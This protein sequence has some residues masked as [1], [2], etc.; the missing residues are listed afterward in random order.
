[1]FS[2]S[3]INQIEQTWNRRSKPPLNRH[4][5]AEIMRIVFFA[6]IRREEG[7]DVAI[8]ASVIPREALGQSQTFA[9]CVRFLPIQ[10]EPIFSVDLAAKLSG[11][12]DT[13]SSSFIIVPDGQQFKVAGIAYFGRHASALDPDP[14]SC[15]APQTLTI[16]ARQPGHLLIAYGNGLI[17]RVTDGEF[18]PGEPTPLV[19]SKLG[20][21]I[22]NRITQHQGF[23][24]HE[25]SYW[26]LYSRCLTRLLTF[27][28]ARGHGGSILWV[29]TSGVENLASCVDIR[30]RFASA[31]DIAQPLHEI[32]DAEIRER[33]ASSSIRG[34]QCP[35][36][37]PVDM[38]A[39]PVLRDKYKRHLNEHLALL[40]QLSCID[41]ALVVDEFLRPLG[42]SAVI[43]LE[44]EWTGPVVSQSTVSPGAIDL[45]KV[46][47]RHKS[48]VA[49]AANCSGAIAF[50]LSQDGPVR[51]IMR[52]GAE[53][54]WW[55]DCFS[56]VFLD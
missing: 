3:L 9:P 20:D 21:A 19:K 45:S 11:A 23:R 32:L 33:T 5:L 1:M 38:M 50:V 55:P 36:F 2:E 12:L 51:G 47:T 41:G 43:K 35:P 24:M 52:A 29:P 16:A 13:R 56:S 39:A 26:H 25:M 40:A 37:V 15:P 4:H 18:T 6:S 48:A 17:G 54:W 31:S 46:G 22:Y 49:F 30:R 34:G 10:P 42:F 8:R 44:P 28:S 53:V 14:S 27:A 7:R